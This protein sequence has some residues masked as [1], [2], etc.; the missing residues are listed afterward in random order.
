MITLRLIDNTIG[1]DLDRLIDRISRPGPRQARSIADAIRQ[2]FQDNFTT[3]GRAAGN[4]WPAL[5]PPTVAARQKL[6]FAG[7][8]PILARTGGY[9]ASFVQRGASDNI[10][11]IRQTSNGLEVVAGSS[12][13]RGR[14]HEFGATVNI[15][16]LQQSR[17]NGLMDVGGA[18]NVYIPPRPV[19]ELGQQSEQR[20]VDVIELML[21]QIE[22]ESLR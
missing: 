18:R 8:H 10:E 11:E 13:E 2:G 3:E 22:R 21:T 17:R 7:Q 4:D 20:I 19:T 5:A 6:G 15:P 16:S 9:R 1:N 14:I 12:S